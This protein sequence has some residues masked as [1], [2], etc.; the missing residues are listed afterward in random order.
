MQTSSLQYPKWQEFT[1]TGG[2]PLQ[3]PQALLSLAQKVRDNTNL[4][5]VTF[6]GY[7]KKEIVAMPY[8][9]AILSN[10]DVLI[11]GRYESKSRVAK[12]LLGSS[13]QTIHLLS[14]RYSLADIQHTP[15]TEVSI[16]PDGSVVFSG[17]SPV[18][19]KL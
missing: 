19:L 11:A 17:V 4:S 18:S 9:D 1:F 6:S 8:G 12:S 3:Q 2:E 13:N 10:I 5:I 7:E 16:K 14:D 15:E